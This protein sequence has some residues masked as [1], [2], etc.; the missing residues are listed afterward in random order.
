MKGMKDVVVVPK[1]GLPQW[2]LG[3]PQLGEM[4]NLDGF[5]CTWPL[6]KAMCIVTTTAAVV[7]TMRKEQF[8]K[9]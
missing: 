4:C 2:P 6:P 1:D 9:H 5:D 8:T 3:P 7:V